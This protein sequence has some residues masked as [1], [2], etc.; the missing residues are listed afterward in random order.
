MNGGDSRVETKRYDIIIAQVND[1]DLTLKKVTMECD[2]VPTEA[3]A[4]QAVHESILDNSEIRLMV[5]RYGRS[6]RTFD[7]STFDEDN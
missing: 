6:F 4:R 2:H 7:A 3:E 1:G 5:M